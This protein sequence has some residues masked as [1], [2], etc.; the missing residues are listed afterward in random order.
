MKYEVS[1]NTY[2]NTDLISA[3]DR[4]IDDDVRVARRLRRQQ[5]VVTLFVVSQLGDVQLKQSVGK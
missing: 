4:Y 1:V 3:A 2:F 5:L